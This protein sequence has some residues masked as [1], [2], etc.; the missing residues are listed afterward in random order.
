MSEKVRCA[1]C[2]WRSRGLT[3]LFSFCATGEIAHGRRVQLS[4]ACLRAQVTPGRRSA[5][6]WLTRKTKAAAHTHSCSVSLR[7]LLCCALRVARSPETLRCA[8][9]VWQSRGLTCLFSFCATGEIA[10]GRR[11]QLSAAC[12]S[13]RERSVRSPASRPPPLGHLCAV[14]GH[15]PSPHTGPHSDYA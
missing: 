5:R 15:S 14:P 9:C 4:A 8:W 12:P 2:V 3:C 1:W 10:H 6:R 13:L 11:V 7:A